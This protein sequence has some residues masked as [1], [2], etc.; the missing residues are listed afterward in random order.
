MPRFETLEGRIADLRRT[1]NLWIAGFVERHKLGVYRER[2][3]YASSI[4]IP[5]VFEPNLLS[6]C[7]ES[8]LRAAG[9][10]V[11]CVAHQRSGYFHWVAEDYLR[12][13]CA[14]KFVGSLCVA[15]C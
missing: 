9:R 14:M 8:S 10:F 4:L 2:S 15:N 7:G 12:T 13:M 6:L 1:V 11:F 5:C 3:E